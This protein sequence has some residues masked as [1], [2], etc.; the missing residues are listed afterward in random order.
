MVPRLPR[1]FE[2]YD[3]AL[4]QLGNGSGFA[5]WFAHPCA[6]RREGPPGTYLEVMQA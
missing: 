2:S 1:L 3:L 6:F 4:A 5:G